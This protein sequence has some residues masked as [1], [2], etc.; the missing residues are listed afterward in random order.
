MENS[1][2]QKTYF[3]GQQIKA[4]F[5]SGNIYNVVIQKI[6]GKQKF[7]TVSLGFCEINKKHITAVIT[8][9]DII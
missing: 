5:S 8:K 1:E 3:L 9:N 6:I 2:T 7:F 4:K